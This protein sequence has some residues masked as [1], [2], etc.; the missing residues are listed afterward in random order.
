M[1]GLRLGP[2]ALNAAF[3][4]D[5]TATV[6]ALRRGV[7]AAQP[8]A[9]AFLGGPHGVLGALAHPLK[10]LT[11]AGVVEAMTALAQP[12]TRALSPEHALLVLGTS[13]VLFMGE[14]LGQ[15]QAWLGSAGDLAEELAAA[16]ALPNAPLTLSTACSSGANGLLL[17]AEAIERNEY[18]SA[19]VVGLEALSPILLEGFRALM[20]VDAHGS[21]P[22]DA[23][24]AG[25]H[26]GECIAAL[27]LT[28]AVRS[29]GPDILLLGGAHV[30]AAQGPGGQAPDAAAMRAVM[31]EALAKSDR[32]PRDLIAVKAHGLGTIESDRAEAQALH[33]LCGAP[34]PPITS[35][36]GS[37]GH[38]LGASGVLE[39]LVFSRCLIAGFI[40]PTAGFAHPDP[41]LD[42]RPLTK[43][44]PAHP[45]CYLLNFFGFG[46]SYVSL[47]LELRA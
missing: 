41:D 6:E 9:S 46:A 16:L 27:C 20:L 15:S 26:L 3:G 10:A 18:R 38:T 4:S 33:A 47:V 36:K 19:L 43:A 35:M 5:L 25:L 2:G 30:C 39:T 1:T 22:F 17:A 11:P 37:F 12:L 13:G 32:A 29:V 34:L 8:P 44:A 7:A 14:Y 45:G 21:K 31:T 42:L 23:H 28:P 24:R 40:P